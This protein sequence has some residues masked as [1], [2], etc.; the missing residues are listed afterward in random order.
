[1]ITEQCMRDLIPSK[2]DAPLPEGLF[3]FRI[4]SAPHSRDV[5]GREVI[6]EKFSVFRDAFERV[7]IPLRNVLH[8]ASGPL[9]I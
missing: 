6:T 5:F 2:R 3:I 8:V 9:V 1:V 7:G 4:G